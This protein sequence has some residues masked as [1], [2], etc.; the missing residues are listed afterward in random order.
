MGFILG[1]LPHGLWIIVGFWPLGTHLQYIGLTP[2]H[3]QRLMDMITLL[4]CDCCCISG[5]VYMSTR[6]DKSKVRQGMIERWIKSWRYAPEWDRSQWSVLI[7]SVNI[8][9]C[10]SELCAHRPADRRWTAQVSPRHEWTGICA[11]CRMHGE[12]VTCT[13]N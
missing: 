5:F 7:L 10:Q 9:W 2:H 1:M 12:N 13:W 4:I 11:T 3:S 8:T 6:D